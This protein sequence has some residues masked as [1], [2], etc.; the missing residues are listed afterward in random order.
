MSFG[1]AAIGNRDEVVAQ[2]GQVQVHGNEIGEKIAALIASQVAAD[3]AQAYGPGYQLAY[4]IKAHGHSG[5]GSPLSLT[6][7]IES[8]PVPVTG[9]A[10]KPAPGTEA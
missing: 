9:P 10:G 6:V 1:F 2:L 4:V 3:P 7:T 8:Q 5:G